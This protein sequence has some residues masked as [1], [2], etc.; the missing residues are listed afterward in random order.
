LRGS[1]RK[2]GRWDF[3]REGGAEKVTES[4]VEGQERVKIAAW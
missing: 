3:Q 2:K 4:F 1:P